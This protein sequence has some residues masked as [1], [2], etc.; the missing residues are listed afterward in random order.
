MADDDL[1]EDF[2]PDAIEEDIDEEVDPEAIDPD[3]IDDDEIVDDDALVSTDVLVDDDIDEAVPVVVEPAVPAV[4]GARGKK[5][6]DSASTSS[7]EEEEEDEDDPDDVEADLDAILKDR[8]AAAEEEDDD[9]DEVDQAP[10]PTVDAPDGVVPK[11]ANEFM[12]MGCFLLVNRG[13]FGPENN[14]QCPVGESEC[15]AIEVLQ[16]TPAARPKA[17]KSGRKR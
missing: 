11:R 8:I 15:P 6:A 5:K 1:D 12:C 2:D 7:E 9:E 13:Q 16:T 10:R 14:L 17:A 4:A 3:A